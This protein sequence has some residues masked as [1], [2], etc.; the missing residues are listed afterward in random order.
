MATI[1]R[2]KIYTIESLAPGATWR[3]QWNNPPAGVVAY[4]AFPNPK[5]PTGQHGVTH[6]T[7]RM[8]PIT[9]HR[10]EDNYNAHEPSYVS[11]E[12]T[13][14]GNETTGVDIYQTWVD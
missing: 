4:I 5:P 14:T 12:I 10:T 1:H 7:V 2:A 3:F 6:G 11:F 8:G 9:T 13:N